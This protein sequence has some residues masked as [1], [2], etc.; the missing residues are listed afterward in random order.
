MRAGG[1]RRLS[2]QIA[3]GEGALQAFLDR[4]QKLV[5][6]GGD[7]SDGWAIRRRRCRRSCSPA[8]AA[9]RL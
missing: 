4:R 6:D 2:G 9:A 1:R 7:S 8:G 5:G 3:R